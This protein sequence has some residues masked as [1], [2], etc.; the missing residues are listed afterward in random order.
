MQKINR[1]GWAAGL[2]FTAYGVRIGVRSN[3]PEILAE[4]RSRFPFGWKA[5]ANPV[6]DTIFSLKVG[7]P[8]RRPGLNQYHLVYANFAQVARTFD[9]EQALALFEQQLQLHV[10]ET[11]RQRVFVHAGVVGWHGKAIVIPG[12][13]LSGKSTLVRELV[14]AGATYYSDEYAVLDTK[15]RVHPHPTPL[16]VRTNTLERQEKLPIETFGGSAGKKPIPVGLVLATEYQDGKRWKPNLMSASQ[17][18]LSLLSNTISAQRNPVSALATLRQIVLKA[19][20]LK[21]V[22][23]ETD[24]VVEALL[25]RPWTTL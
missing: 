23:G 16:G 19:P 6:V 15:G 14:K 8:G 2:A 22:R 10:A 20:I 17:G 12:R 24:E 18:L 5:T 7:G 13:S 4:L 25:N 9:L 21:G 3:T 1:L 11:A